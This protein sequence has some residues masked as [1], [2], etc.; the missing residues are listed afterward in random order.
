MHN[1]ERLARI[2][3][4]STINHPRDL[5]LRARSIILCPSA[6]PLLHRVRNITARHT[7]PTPCRATPRAITDTLSPQSSRVYSSLVF[8]SSSLSP[9]SS[10]PRGNTIRWEE[11]GKCARCFPANPAVNFVARNSKSIALLSEDFGFGRRRRRKGE[12]C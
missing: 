6:P 11:G 5:T 1:L 12:K 9:S 7:E 10:S 4:G 2:Y 3:A 8:F